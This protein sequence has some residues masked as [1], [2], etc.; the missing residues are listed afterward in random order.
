MHIH[1]CVYSLNFSYTKDFQ[2]N[3]ISYF[4]LFLSIQVYSVFWMEQY[5]PEGTANQFATKPFMML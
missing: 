1:M 5:F 3:Q 4:P 2:I